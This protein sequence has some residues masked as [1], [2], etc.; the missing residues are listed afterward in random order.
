MRKKLIQKRLKGTEVRRITCSSASSLAARMDRHTLTADS[1]S[2]PLSVSR[3]RSQS[4][5]KISCCDCGRG[6]WGI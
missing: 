3:G 2:S 1:P 6:G 4:S 5:R